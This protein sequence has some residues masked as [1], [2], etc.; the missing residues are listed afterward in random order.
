MAT[1]QQVRGDMAKKKP[2]T[3][4]APGFVSEEEIFK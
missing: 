4:R 2:G 3:A 1:P